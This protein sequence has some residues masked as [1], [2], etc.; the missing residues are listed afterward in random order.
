MSRVL[1]LTSRKN[2]GDA[3]KD[4]LTDEGHVVD[5]AEALPRGKPPFDE[6]SADVVVADFE[7]WTWSGRA[8]LDAWALMRRPPRLVL[9]G[10]R[11]PGTRPPPGLIYLTKPVDLADLHTAI[12]GS[13]PRGERNA[14]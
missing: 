8:I 9:L 2:D 14:A 13:T 10:T 11:C 5:L 1:L 12:T 6:P 4:L 7:P 3:L